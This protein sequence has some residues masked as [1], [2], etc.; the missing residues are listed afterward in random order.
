MKFIRKKIK[1]E[2]KI[3]YKVLKLTR[4]S[5]FLC[6]MH[7]EISSNL[8]SYFFDIKVWLNISGITKLVKDFFLIWN[9]LIF[10]IFDF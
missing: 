9:P 2:K 8:S 3:F 6:E 4:I 7:F 1:N 5:I 10:V